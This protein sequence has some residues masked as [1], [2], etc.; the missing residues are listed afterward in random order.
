MPKSISLGETSLERADKEK[1]ER[2]ILRTFRIRA[3]LRTRSLPQGIEWK[4]TF[5]INHLIERKD[6]LK[7]EE[8]SGPL[9]QC[10]SWIGPPHT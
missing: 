7:V 1:P 4:I 2:I 10:E 9:H 8:V 5:R 3:R 6:L